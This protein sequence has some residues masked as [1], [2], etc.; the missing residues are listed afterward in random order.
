VRLRFLAL[1]VILGA[2]L[3]AW[4]FGTDHGLLAI[5]YQGQLIETSVNV[6]L[7]VLALGALLCYA[8]ARLVAHLWSLER[9]LHGWAHTQRTG[10]ARQDLVAGAIAL[11]EGHWRQ[12]EESL[13]RSAEASETPFLHYLAAARAAQAQRAPDRR[14]H[15]L[16]LAR[17]TTPEADLAVGLVATELHLANG[18]IAEAR[19][20]LSEM[21]SRH[22]NHPEVLRVALRVHSERG[23]WSEILG[24][25]PALSK[26]KA[27]SAEDMLARQ[28]EAHAGLLRAAADPEALERAWAEVPTALRKRPSVLYA[29]AAQLQRYGDASRVVPLIHKTLKADWDS[30]L[31]ACYGSIDSEDT[32]AQIR[33]A[34]TWLAA[35]G[36]DPSLLLTLGRLCYKS[37]LWGKACY[38]FEA[39]IAREPYPEAYW[40]LA[41]TLDHIGDPERA[42]LS[43]R[44]GLDLATHL[45]EAQL[46]GAR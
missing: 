10:R 15:Y 5:A 17:E 33:E 22:P 11:A 41:E 28:I 4:L 43:R 34:E 37:G 32:A 8:S 27:L 12:A 44:K 24:L 26:R 36:D 18:E 42:A 14:D 40:L 13:Y 23:E 7:V 21:R 3:L 9:R 25:L 29:Y 20:V 45:R 2:V 30:A 19:A 38:Y 39:S 31:C 1:L 6:A 46:P 16:G 35:H